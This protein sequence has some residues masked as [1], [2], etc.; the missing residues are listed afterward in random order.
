M[1]SIWPAKPLCFDGR[2]A[3][4]FDSI[5]HSPRWPEQSESRLGSI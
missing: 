2:P 3:A 5:P 1:A 4:R